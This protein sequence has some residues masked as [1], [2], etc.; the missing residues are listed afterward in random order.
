MT[1]DLKLYLDDV[2]NLPEA[3]LSKKATREIEESIQEM[4]RG[5]CVTLED[6]KSA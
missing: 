5:K 1:R 6:L 2:L 4:K 3:T